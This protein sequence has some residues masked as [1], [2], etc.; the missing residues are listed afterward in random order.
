MRTTAAL[1]AHIYRPSVPSNCRVTVDLGLVLT[2]TSGEA[3][4]FRVDIEAD[5]S[6]ASSTTAFGTN[7]LVSDS[8]GV[9]ATIR[10]V[11]TL[12]DDKTK[13]RP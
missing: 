4:A 3:A 7:V 2:S 12:P 6:S 11:V 10:V 13:S 8:L 5:G 1:Y 9:A